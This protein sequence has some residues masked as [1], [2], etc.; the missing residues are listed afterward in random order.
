MD[1]DFSLFGIMGRARDECFP[2]MAVSSLFMAIIVLAS[3]LVFPCGEIRKV[4]LSVKLALTCS[5]LDL[6]GSKGV[7]MNDAV[8]SGYF[9]ISG[10]ML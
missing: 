8:L 10:K 5:S 7:I 6:V 3:S 4:A 9:V 1:E 2:V